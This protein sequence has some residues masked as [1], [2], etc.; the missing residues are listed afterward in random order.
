M[1]LIFSILLV[2]LASTTAIAQSAVPSKDQ[3]D[4]AMRRTFGYD[5]AV[6]WE[7][8]A[9]KPS[10]IAGLAEVVV[11]INKQQPVHLYVSADARQAI[12]GESI[13][14]GVDPFSA[15][16][17]LLTK[18]KG[19]ARGGEAMTIVVFGNLDCLGCKAAQP[20]L[21]RLATDFPQVHQLFEILPLPAGNSKSGRRAALW[22]DCVG[23]MSPAKFWPFVD[24]ILTFPDGI[25][26]DAAETGLGA[27]SGELGLDRQ[28]LS[29]CASSST[30]SADLDASQILAQSLGVDEVPTLFVNGRRVLRPA[31]LPADQL[32]R[33]VQ[34]ELDHSGR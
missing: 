6:F 10:P 1:K 33:L 13:P 19:P 25:N 3:V 9:I 30:A 5:P 16:R 18:A 29:Q 28:A 21:D 4:A 34:F 32:K 31:K 12:V 27:A 2:L 23:R 22:A 17:T 8:V 15:N 11:S 26:L 7:I 20:M 24:R 14:F